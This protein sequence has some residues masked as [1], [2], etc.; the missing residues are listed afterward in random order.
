[1]LSIDEKSVREAMKL[2]P[3]MGKRVIQA[4]KS[5]GFIPKG[6][7]NNKVMELFKKNIVN[8]LL[9]LYD[10]VDPSIR[11]RSKLWYV[12]ANRISEQMAKKYKISLRQVAGIMAAMSPQK[13]WFQNVSMAERAIDILTKQG[14]TAWSPDMIEYAESYVNEST[15][16]REKEKREEAFEKIK[17]VAAKGT[18]LKDMDPKSAAAFIRAYDE[19]F[20]SRQYKI[21]TPEGG[22]GDLVTNNDG[23]PST[24]MWSNYDPIEKT[25]KMFRD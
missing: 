18:K 19:A 1:M 2:N 14:N 12:G 6:T 5:Y 3:D 17:K 15:D 8:N 25:V 7:P 11:E 23:T 24:L 21:V 10:G 4:I 9:F 13:D 22:F 20:N 16:R